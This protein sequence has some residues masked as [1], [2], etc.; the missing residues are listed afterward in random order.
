[1][2]RR[3]RYRVVA[4]LGRRL[5]LSTDLDDG[6]DS[7]EEDSDLENLDED[8]D[9]TTL[10]ETRVDTRKQSRNLSQKQKE[11][12]VGRST[13]VDTR[14]TTNTKIQTTVPRRRNASE[15]KDPRSKLLSL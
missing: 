9:Q 6:I 12:Q 1:M 4:E 8:M 14:Q 13:K 10:E 7:E 3:L 2:E 15:T 11:P 5:V